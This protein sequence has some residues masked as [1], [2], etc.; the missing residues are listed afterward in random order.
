MSTMIIKCKKRANK[1]N[2]QDEHRRN[3]EAHFEEW[4]SSAESMAFLCCLIRARCCCLFSILNT[5]AR[6][7]NK[8]MDSQSVNELFPIMNSIV[9]FLR[10]FYFLR[11]TKSRGKE[12]RSLLLSAVN[13]IPNFSRHMHKCKALTLASRD[14][15]QLLSHTQSYKN[16]E[17][18]EE[19]RKKLK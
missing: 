5:W 13:T 8:G 2:V 4:E 18:I 1:A 16:R 17:R 3:S 11:D 6:D 12:D 9:Q 7:D 15:L 14:R 19:E 10:S